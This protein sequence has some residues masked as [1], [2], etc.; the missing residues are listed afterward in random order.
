MEKILLTFRSKPWT[1]F[2]VMSENLA[3]VSLRQC[4]YPKWAFAK[5]SKHYINLQHQLK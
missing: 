3:K 4:G 2:T 5:A 1:L